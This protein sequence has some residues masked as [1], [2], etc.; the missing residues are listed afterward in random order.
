MNKKIII[1]A[2]C[3][4][5]PIVLYLLYYAHITRIVEQQQQAADHLKD[6]LAGGAILCVEQ[7]R[8]ERE[9][10]DKLPAGTLAEPLDWPSYYKEEEKK[11]TI[12]CAKV[13]ACH[14]GAR[15]WEEADQKKK[16][17]EAAEAKRL[18]EINAQH[19]QDSGVLDDW[20]KQQEEKLEQERA[21][22]NNP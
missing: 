20:K 19:A 12:Y 15:L 22:R 3:L 8:G 5:V 2:I 21:K 11:S 4:L 13:E 16:E 18:E 1:S 10:V 6:V 17:C 9:Q 7:A 14:W